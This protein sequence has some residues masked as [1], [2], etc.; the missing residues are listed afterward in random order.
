MINHNQQDHIQEEMQILLNYLKAN[1]TIEI[2]SN[3][4]LV[5]FVDILHDLGETDL[6]EKF[7]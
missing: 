5:A 1:R 7:R 2:D 6:V 3:T 4:S